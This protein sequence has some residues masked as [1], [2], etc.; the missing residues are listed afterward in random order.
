MDGKGWMGIAIVALVA[1]AVIAIV[2]R[3]SKLRTWVTAQP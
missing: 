3:V 1:V 2:F